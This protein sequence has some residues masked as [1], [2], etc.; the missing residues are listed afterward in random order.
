MCYAIPGK[1]IAIEGRRVTL[2]YFGEKR[3]AIHELPALALG[4]Y[5]YAQGGWV[6]DRIDPAEAASILEF[7][8]EQFFQ[9]Q[10][11]DLR[12]S[13]LSSEK[14]EIDRHVAVVFDRAIEELPLRDEELLTL[15]E[16]KSGHELDYLYK[17][18]NFL[19]YK[20]QGNSCCI[21]GIIEF[22][23]HCS[24]SC[25]YCG[26]S[27]WNR[28]LPR[29][30]LTREE[31]LEAVREA[32][33][34]WGFKALVLQSGED[35]DR[36]IDELAAIITEIRA[37]WPLLIFISCGEVGI[38]GLQRL[39]NA[40]ARGLLMRFETSN[41]ELYARIRPGRILENRMEQLRAARDMGYLLITGGL[42]GIPGQTSRDLLNDILLARSLRPDMY[43]FGP[44]I[45]HPATPLAKAV[46]PSSAEVRKVLAVCRIADP[47][48][49]RLVV[50]TAFETLDETAREQGLTS[51]A[52]SVMM[53]VTPDAV[54]PSYEL[55]PDR[56]HARESISGQIDVTLNLLGRLGR[57]PTDLGTRDSRI[58][59]SSVPES[60]TNGIPDQ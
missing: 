38:P 42:I 45:P 60:S 43:S 40:G 44:L 24:G 58:L 23:S 34:I 39:F 49:S 5:V 7:W 59:G 15:L 19:R 6:I 29:Y 30:R 56:A 10:A 26:I 27:T 17:V 33:E 36:P 31:I 3:E 9:L 47:R 16:L 37:R 54:R 1:I 4:D 51:G 14:S 8:R 53:N 12:L 21:H 35:P 41:P 55:Y 11:T 18:A 22:S 20:H 28:E 57:A 2:E 32:V 48:E 52:N 25:L 13:R 46:S 50:T